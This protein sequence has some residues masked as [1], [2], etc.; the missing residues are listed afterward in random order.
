MNEIKSY[1]A[2]GLVYGHLWG[3]GEGS[4]L[5][6]ELSNDTLSGIIEEINQGIVDGSLDSGM[7]Y[8]SLIGA[9]MIIEMEQKVIIN[10][11][12]YRNTTTKRYYS[13]GLSHKQKLFL[14]RNLY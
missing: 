3:G 14:S 7:G 6:E 12:A 4:Y 1:K 9:L 10:N 5:A 11:K 13:K 2:R 8:E